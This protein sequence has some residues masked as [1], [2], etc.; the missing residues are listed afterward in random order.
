MTSFFQSAENR[1]LGFLSFVLSLT[2]L[3]FISREVKPL[4]FLAIVE[5]TNVF[6]LAY[7]VLF[8]ATI[9]SIAF[10]AKTF[11]WHTWLS[12][13]LIV[14]FPVE[15]LMSFAL[16]ESKGF[17]YI[18][19]VGVG[20]YILLAGIALTALYHRKH[21]TKE[22]SSFSWKQWFREQGRGTLAILALAVVMYTGFGLCNISH[23]SAV[24]EPLWTFGRVQRYWKNISEH[25]WHKTRVSDKPGITVSIISGIGLLFENPKEH[26]TTPG[27]AIRHFIPGLDDLNTAL[28][29]PLLLFTALML[30]VFYFLIE[31]LMGREKALFSTILIASSSILLG[32]SRIIN[33]DAILWTFVP[34]SMLSYFVFLK[35]KNLHYLY[36][37][38]IFLG[39]ALLTKYVANIVFVFF[40]G[41]IFLEY[42]FMKT[43]ERVTL[44]PVAYFKNAL[45]QYLIVTFCALAV[46]YTLLPAA[47]VKPARLLDA[48]LLSQAFES[49]WP[50]F[51]G[52]FAFLFLDQWLLRNKVSAAI[53]DF[54]AEK[55]K[56]VVTIITGFFL[57]CFLIVI[58]N[59]LSGMSIYDFQETL[60]SPKT[61]YALQGFDSVFFGNFYSLVFGIAP[62]ALVFCI[63]ALILLLRHA[64]APSIAVK[65]AFYLI[66]FILLYYLG[67]TV[68]HVAAISRYQIIIF[69]L[70]LILAGIALGAF[71]RNIS[72]RF[73]AVSLPIMGMVLLIAG[74]ISLWASS[75]IYL[76]YGSSLL[77]KQYNINVKDMGTGSYEAAEY[78][79]SLPDAENLVIWTD[80]TGIC[81]VFKGTCYGGFNFSRMREKGLDYIVVSS[82]R[83]PRTTK[84][85]HPYIMS[86]KPSI[87]RF[88]EYYNKQDGTAFKLEIDGRPGD[89]IKVFPFVE[90]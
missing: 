83:Q 66:I 80:K 2:T 67:S 47:W 45:T 71:F 3:F 55:R 4:Q 73:P 84:M 90:E 46:F 70:G 7:V 29:S 39:L 74:F 23:F 15:V 88:D 87:I 85:M 38:G 8:V 42:M 22:N 33:P 32:M 43:E 49:T 31:R 10:F 9:G 72:N 36:W 78:L 48:T 27:T 40:F 65:T 26:K 81:G 19:L 69:P 89:Y 34:L 59:V 16:T 12:K 1:F 53:L 50:L 25:E 6:Y 24:D 62:V 44:D 60:A 52:I 61:A 82:G 63:S 54:M 76:G 35:R 18:F 13:M 77:P 79:N 37:S 51:I 58:G 86:A 64:Q 21:Q 57:V 5:D 68:N 11:D 41:L 28:R 56:W 30:P 75:P 14:F 17:H 20:F